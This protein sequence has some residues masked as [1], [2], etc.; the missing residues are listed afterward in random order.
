MATSVIVPIIIVGIIIV[1][2]YFFIKNYRRMVEFRNIFSEGS[3]WGLRRN[4]QGFVSGISGNGNN[5]FV[6]IK[7]SIN[8]YLS[9]NT[10]AV[11]DFQLLKDAVDRH[12][13]SVEDDISAQT[14]VPLYCGLAGTMAGVICGLFPLI[15]SGTLIYLLSGNIPKGMVKAQMDALAAHGIN[16]LL[17]GV[18]W[19]MI[20]SICGILLTTVS[21]LLFKAHKLKEESGKNSFLA[22][23]QS[24]LL[25]ELPS[26]TSEALN[27]LVKNLNRFNTTFAQNTSELETTLTR[28]NEVYRTQDNIIQAVKDMDV[29]K[30]AR[31]NVQVLNALQ[32]CTEQIGE[33]SEYLVAVNEYTAVIRTFT[34]RFESESDRLHVLEEIRDFFTRHKG[35]IAHETADTDNALKEA[36]QSLRNTSHTS[37]TEFSGDIVRQSEEFKSIL[38][39][40]KATFERVAQEIRAQFSDQLQQMPM[41]QQNL[42]RISTIPAA[43]DQLISRIEKSNLLLADKVNKTMN[44]T[45]KA[46]TSNQPTIEDLPE[47]KPQGVPKWMKWTATVGIII[48]ALSCLANTIYTFTKSNKAIPSENQETAVSE[49][50]AVEDTTTVAADTVV[51]SSY[52]H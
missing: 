49:T 8:K 32:G 17:T 14:P 9:N 47:E 52:H 4:S 12:C 19:A 23:M 33:L 25:P 16:E 18:A 46:I 39:E 51:G 2:L 34:E 22:W 26:D 41:L 15:L 10:G 31:A 27:R 1:Q 20:S 11:I 24:S 6:S 42:E 3:S 38:Q 21:S 36:L 5:V 7:Q 43:L 35:E 48:I 44:A 40:E 50:I 30:M 45:V 13:D 37:L 29:M 28:V